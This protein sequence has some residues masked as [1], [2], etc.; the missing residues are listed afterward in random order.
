MKIKTIVVISCFFLSSLI[1]S[2]SSSH[3]NHKRI[4]KITILG[5]SITVGFGSSG[6]GYI[7]YIC[8]IENCKVSSLGLSGSSIAEVS[9]DSVLS[10]VDRCGEIDLDTDL[11]IIFG[12]TNDYW[13]KRVSIGTENSLQTSELYGA[14]EYIASYLH[15]NYC[16]SEV[17][18][19]TPYRSYYNGN[20]NDTNFGYGILADFCEAIQKFAYKKN[21]KLI[22]L[23]KDFDLDMSIS[24]QRKLYANSDDDGIHLNDKG[25]E[26]LGIFIKDKLIEM[27]F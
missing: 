4:R 26:L 20:T 16:N 5:D 19:I 24:E 10:F 14:L 13:H 23:Y 15:E 27:Y 17:C 6:N 3:D 2:C 11:I 21:Y 8:S 7:P 25:Y 9:D 18:F 12:G 1:F 22:N